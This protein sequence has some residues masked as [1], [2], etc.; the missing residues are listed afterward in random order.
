MV[1]Y[2]INNLLQNLPT[3]NN[4]INIDLVLDGGLFNGSYLIGCLHFLKSLEKNNYVKINR[5]SGSSVGAA[6]ALLYAIDELDFSIEMNKLVI[7]QL[8][9]KYK[10]PIIKNFKDILFKNK[11]LSEDQTNDILEKV[12]NFLYI[13]YYKKSKR[14][15]LFR[16][17]TKKTYKTIDE[18]FDSIFRSCFVPFLVDGNLL[19]KNKYFDGITP[20]IFKEIKNR[21]ILYL[22]LCANDKLF[23]MINI[24][25]EKSDYHRVLTGILDIHLFFIKQTNT[26]M[27]SY[28][29]QWSL[30][31]KID[32]QYKK[33]I[34][35][36]I[37]VF[38]IT[39]LI[40]INKYISKSKSN[41]IK[42][43]YKICSQSFFFL[44]K[45]LLDKCIR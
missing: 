21:K 12:N 9:K 27:C 41:D 8:K 39:L 4:P 24:K 34:F 28:V 10:I 30:F 35:E 25:N 13:S 32:S 6:V 31:Y 18:L 20:F 26:S 2:Y 15:L 29:N 40:Y 42:T 33:Y 43:F 45:H 37:A 17:K 14:D 7:N 19:H 1:E 22:N 23:H 36:Y 38:L 5:I 11:S 44:Y 3:R 16:K